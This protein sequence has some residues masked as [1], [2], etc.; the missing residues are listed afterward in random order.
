MAIAALITGISA[1]VLII[2]GIIGVIL[3]IVSLGRIRRNGT[4]GK[5]MA[6]A[7]IIV[8][9]VVTLFWGGIITVIVVS[10][11]HSDGRGEFSFGD[12]YSYGDNAALDRLWNQCDSGDMQA[13]DDL[14]DQ[15]DVGSDYENFGDTCG[16]REPA[17]TGY[18]CTSIVTPDSGTL[19]TS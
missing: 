18:L 19:P 5:G 6:I 2:T 11:T 12:N 8:G 10:A 16:D 7:G 9:G 1:L 3:G 13:C 14:Y 4:G 15:S 17:G